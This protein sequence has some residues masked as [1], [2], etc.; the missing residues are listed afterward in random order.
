MNELELFNQVARIAKPPHSQF[1]PFKSFEAPFSGSDVDS[2]DGLLIIMYMC[3]IY[4]IG[5]D[6]AKDFYPANPKEMFDF[7]HHNKTQEPESLEAAVELCK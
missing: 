7:I 6:T 1:T 2:L 5:D 4:G 3:M